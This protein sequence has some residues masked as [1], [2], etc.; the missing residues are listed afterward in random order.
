[1]LNGFPSFW[2]DGD[3][4]PTDQFNCV[5]S[6]VWSASMSFQNDQSRGIC[7]TN[8]KEWFDLPD[9]YSYSQ[10]V[11]GEFYY[12]SYGEMTAETARA[13][14]EADGAS[15]PVPRSTNENDFYAALYPSGQ[16]WLGLT[17]THDG[18]TVT[19]KNLDGTEA[20]F[21]NWGTDYIYAENTSAAGAYAYIDTRDLSEGLY[22]DMNRWNNNKANSDLANAVCVYKIPSEYETLR[23]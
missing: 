9:D 23:Y 20:G 18:T 11:W 19:T 21:T 15:L 6:E 22:A 7:N 3:A 17:T 4:L 8:L 12:K 2:I 16:V 5:N 14:C 13:Q 10:E 1:M